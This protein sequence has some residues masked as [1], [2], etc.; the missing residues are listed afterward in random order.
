MLGS[1]AADHRLGAVGDRAID[2]ARDLLALARVDQRA[3]H[4][5]RGRSGRRTRRRRASSRA[6]ST[7]FVVA[8]ARHD[9]ARRDRAALT[10]VRGRRVRA[11]Q[12]GHREVA[13]VEQHERRLAAEL[14]E[15]ALHG[16]A[17]GRHDLAAD[18]RR[19]GERHDVDVGMRRQLRA[20]RV[21]GRRRA[22]SRR[23]AGCRSRS[24]MSLPSASVAHGVSGAPLSTTVHPAAS[25]GASFA[26]RELDRVVVRRD[27]ADDA[28]GFLLDP[29]VVSAARTCRARRG[30]RRTRS[31]RA[32]RRTS[33][34]TSVGPSS[35][36]PSVLDDRRADLVHEDLAERLGVV[37]QRLV[38][39]AQAAHAE[40]PWSRDHVVVSNARR[41]AAIARSASAT[42]ASAAAPST[43]SVA[44]EIVSYV[45]PFSAATSSPSIE[46]PVLV[47]DRHP[48]PP[49]DRAGVGPRGSSVSISPA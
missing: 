24:A 13:V 3:H 49:H 48:L 39:L 23:P 40:A 32:G 21:V 35:C 8:V 6:A 14:E 22:R 42:L 36:G 9:E 7:D 44:G 4:R 45:A 16:R 38:E 15:H 47:P 1:A 46:Q 25:A 43:S 12:R 17:R 26:E 34:T 2:V 5:S 18:R 31:P 37:E 30:P 29:A 19:A 28:G 33:C 10:R 27:R 11:E 41:A 20:D